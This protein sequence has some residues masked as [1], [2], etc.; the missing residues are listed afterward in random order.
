MHVT[1]TKCPGAQ[2]RPSLYGGLLLPLHAAEGVVLEYEAPSRLPNSAGSGAL[3][4]PDSPHAVRGAISTLW[5][6]VAVHLKEKMVAVSPANAT[7]HAREGAPK[8]WNDVPRVDGV[9]SMARY[10]PS[11]P[12]PA[13]RYGGIRARLLELSHAY[14]SQFRILAQRLGALA[15]RPHEF[16]DVRH[17]APLD[18]PPEL[19][20]RREE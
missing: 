12:R 2:R 3:Q 18:E 13:A 20:S 11:Y 10:S 16:L 14:C 17:G 5:G 19:V 6:L 9:A 15:Q 4:R 8:L 1:M 7:R